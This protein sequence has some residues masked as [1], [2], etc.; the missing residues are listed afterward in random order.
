MA[1]RF[2]SVLI[3]ISASASSAAQ[4]NSFVETSRNYAVSDLPTLRDMF[5]E[6][7]LHWL[8]LVPPSD[9]TFYQNYTVAVPIEWKSLPRAFLKKMVGEL[10]EDFI[11]IYTVSVWE[12]P[13]TF[14]T[15]FS[16]EGREIW[17]IAARNDYDPYAWFKAQQALKGISTPVCDPI[18]SQSRVGC[19]FSLIPSEFYE[20]Y[21]LFQKMEPS[22]K[23]VAENA[24]AIA[25]M[26]L[27]MSNELKVSIS[28]PASEDS[29]TINLLSADSWKM[30]EIYFADS[31]LN[32]RWVVARAFF[33]GRS[34]WGG[35]RAGP[36]LNPVHG[37]YRAAEISH[38][39]SDGLSCAFEEM[40]LGTDPEKRDTDGN[41]IKDGEEDFDGDGLSNLEEYHGILSGR[42]SSPL[43]A[44][45]DNDGVCDG[46]AVPH[47]GL[48]PGPD[49]FPL[50]PAGS[51]D[52]D[53][54]GM[55]DEIHGISS[56]YPPLVED[57]DDD[58]DR[59]L[60]VFELANGLDP[61]NASDGLN[62]SDTDG[63]GLLDWWE[64]QY[65]LNHLVSN[66]VTID[67]DDDGLTLS[68]EYQ[69]GTDPGQAD[70][71]GDGV[72]DGLEV[73][74]GMNP[75]KPDPGNRDIDGDGLT[76]LEEIAHQSNPALFDSDGD[77]LSDAE[78]ILAGSD[79][80]RADSDGDGLSDGEEINI[81]GTDPNNPDSDG[82]GIL[83]SVDM[84]PASHWGEGTAS[85]RE[86]Q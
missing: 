15:V 33:S 51:I 3:M 50:D 70:T 34:V 32:P 60:D 11:P 80:A 1:V 47:P 65:G 35:C 44:D 42:P 79:P 82:N 4:V 83:D 54:D 85:W 38:K 81:Y 10:N 24:E 78:E 56:S 27:M 48:I 43:H 8:H 23:A 31:L 49:A 46:P 14:E 58:N 57:L 41:G 39:D 2:I 63:D 18:Y 7:Q 64:K 19:R 29:S 17:R 59:L 73:T 26:A 53:G 55:P 37:F 71:D 75:L 77:Q 16:S 6:H 84:L 67:A 74:Y 69:F 52:T 28:D 76:L 22:E 12:D 86:L 66:D 36:G 13:I 62:D 45:T 40:V 61:K 72:P 30:Y 25:P 68:E 9:F 20:D 21:L 5:V